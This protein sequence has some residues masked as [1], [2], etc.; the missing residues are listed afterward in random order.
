MDAVFTAG[1][2]K[3][4][5]FSDV[6]GNPAFPDRSFLEDCRYIHGKLKGRQLNQPE[7]KLEIC[8]PQ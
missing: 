8:L 3:G 7:L 1:K 5:W 4:R 6:A 2:F